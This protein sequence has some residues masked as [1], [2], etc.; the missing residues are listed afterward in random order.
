MRKKIIIVLLCLL[1]MMTTLVVVEADL[2]VLSEEPLIQPAGTISLGYTNI[3]VEQAYNLLTNTSNGIQI[4][5]DVR[6]NSEWAIAHIDTPAPENPQHWPYL[7]NGENLTEFMQLYEG[8]EIIVYCK[9]GSRS[10]AA[11]KLLVEHNFTGVIYMML[12][13]IDGWTQAGYPTKPNTTPNTPTITGDAKGKP[14]ENYSYAVTTTDPDADDVSYYVNWTDNTTNQLVGPFHSA[15]EATISHIWSEKGTY[16][17]KVKARDI[18][19]SESDYATLEVKMP[20]TV[21]NPLGQFLEH[22]FERFP[23]L[24]PVLQQLLGY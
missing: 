2:S 12:G 13:G 6:T 22:L 7:Q 23:N 9:A 8:K 20:Y 17:I 18:Y 11:A 3:T 24:F 15:E 10:T 19:G 14:G 16:I 4:P 5:I 1:L 21:N